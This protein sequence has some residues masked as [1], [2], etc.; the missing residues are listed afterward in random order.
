MRTIFTTC[1]EHA[2]TMRRPVPTYYSSL[3]FPPPDSLNF[4]F[5]NH[6]LVMARRPTNKRR[7]RDKNVLREG[8]PDA[9]MQVSYIREKRKQK[10]GTYKSVLV[11]ESLHPGFD[12]PAPTSAIAGPS[13]LE[14]PEEVQ[15]MDNADMDDVVISRKVPKLHKVYTS[16]SMRFSIKQFKLLYRRPSGITLRNLLTVLTHYWMHCCL[17]KRYI[18]QTR[19]AV[20]VTPIDGLRGD[21]WIARW[22]SRCVGNVCGKL[23]CAVHFTKF[24]GGMVGIIARLNSGKSGAISW[25]SIGQEAASVGDF[26]CRSNYWKR[27]KSARIKPTNQIWAARRKNKIFRCATTAMMKIPMLLWMTRRMRRT[28]RWMNSLPNCMPDMKPA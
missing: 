2:L 6:L 23:T 11:A 5:A 27:A 20:A 3:I 17:G 7:T 19:N 13:Q 24:S 1:S 9:S 18:W 4:G 16:V 14:I 25:C 28:P 10:S 8:D 12:T 26:D 21:A 22:Q 15:E